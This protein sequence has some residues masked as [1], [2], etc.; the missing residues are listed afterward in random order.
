MHFSRVC[1]S[2][3]Y[4]DKNIYSGGIDMNLTNTLDYFIAITGSLIMI[5]SFAWNIYEVFIHRSQ[6]EESEDSAIR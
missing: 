5:V 6:S 4:N 1:L 3:R 2:F